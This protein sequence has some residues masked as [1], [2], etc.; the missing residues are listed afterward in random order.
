MILSPG[1]MYRPG[2]NIGSG[3]YFVVC[4]AATLVSDDADQRMF[5]YVLFR[6]NE[7]GDDPYISVCHR[8]PSAFRNWR[9]FDIVSNHGTYQE[10]T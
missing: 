5:K 9:R 8:R 4:I 3:N 2:K 7:P 10:V 1:G 6:Y